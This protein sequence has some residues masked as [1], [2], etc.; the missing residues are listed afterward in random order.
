MSVGLAFVLYLTTSGLILAWAVY[1]RRGMVEQTAELSDQVAELTRYRESALQVAR[2]AEHDAL[3]WESPILPP[4]WVARIRDALSAT[5]D[6]CDCSQCQDAPRR[7]RRDHGTDLLTAARP[8]CCSACGGTGNSGD[9]AT[10]GGQCWDCRMTG[11]AHA[12]DSPCES[13]A[14]S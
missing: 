11:H 9:D 10:P 6:R 1:S 5:S 4:E 2:E 7:W 3:R 14:R 12:Q 8:G 13:E